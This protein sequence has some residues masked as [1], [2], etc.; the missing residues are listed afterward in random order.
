MTALPV[1]WPSWLLLPA[2]LL[3]LLALAPAG[4]T[5]EQGRP[6]A[7]LEGT[8]IFRRILFEMGLKPLYERPEGLVDEAGVQVEPS[9]TI[10]IILGDPV[11]PVRDGVIRNFLERGGAILFA[12]DQKVS[13][14]KLKKELI[15][16]T[17]C[18]IA[19]ETFCYKDRWEPNPPSYHRFEQC[20]ILVPRKGVDPNLFLI[21]QGHEQQPLRVATN[22]PSCLEKSGKGVKAPFRELASL[23]AGCFPELFTFEES[24]LSPSGERITFWVVPD[25]QPFAVGGSFENGRLLL[26]ADHSIFINM[27]MSRPDIDNVEFASNC[28]DYLRTSS[29]GSR[30]H[31]LFLEEGEVKSNFKISLKEVPGLSEKGLRALMLAL[32]QHLAH[33]EDQDAFNHFARQRIDE[34]KVPYVAV[35]V[36][37]GL[38]L[39]WALWRLRQ[40]QGPHP[41]K[42]LPLLAEA[43]GAG[44]GRP[45]SLL[46]HRQQELRKNGN[47]WE[48][49]RH[50][51]RET[52]LSAGV[53]APADPLRPP[54]INATGTFWQRWQKRRQV[55]R[56]WRLAFD[57]RPVRV[58]PGDWPGLLAQLEQLQADLASGALQVKSAA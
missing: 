6:A 32:E 49:A 28:V 44:P 52:F 11:H 58:R 39:A 15:E 40:F 13:D 20:P 34:R 7:G 41:E 24:R 25:G 51:A 31:V 46:E 8:E 14:P 3:V 10:L 47:L 48:N 23:P 42:A 12:S 36:L 16:L 18:T 53:A 2:T 4:Q 33:L 1:R 50:L 22:R 45:D 55:L 56:L 26:L 9:K 30:D 21:D 19:G 54:A 17:G 37:T 43:L 29:N 57:P 38:L 5:Q 27:M 35:L